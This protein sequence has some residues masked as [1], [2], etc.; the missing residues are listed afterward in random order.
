M[1]DPHGPDAVFAPAA[2]PR[3]RRNRRRFLRSILCLFSA[4]VRQSA[5]FLSLLGSWAVAGD[6][7]P[8]D[9]RPH[10]RAS[11]R[12]GTRGMEPAPRERVPP[13]G[14]WPSARPPEAERSF[15]QHM[16]SEMSSRG[17]RPLD[18]YPNCLLM[19][20]GLLIQIAP[21]AS[22]A[23]HRAWRA[24]DDGERLPPASS[25]A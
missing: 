7:T 15:R 24:C 3:R 11:R 14:L 9:R 10:L 6:L 20:W 25:G 22:A 21:T 1:V 8:A 16:A 12:S 17:F 23:P 5:R 18:W 4:E 2:L 13:F 19:A